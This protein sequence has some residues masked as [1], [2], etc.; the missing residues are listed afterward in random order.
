MW[1]LCFVLY[2]YQISKCASGVPRKKKKKSKEKKK[3]CLICSFNQALV[4]DFKK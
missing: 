2:V 4:L 3:V 1:N